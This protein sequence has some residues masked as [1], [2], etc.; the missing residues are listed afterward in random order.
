MGSGLTKEQRIEIWNNQE[1]Y[2]GVMV[3]IQ[4]FEETTNQNGGKSLRFPVFKTFRY[5]KTPDDANVE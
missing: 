5:D 3:E 2:L 4:Y 1:D